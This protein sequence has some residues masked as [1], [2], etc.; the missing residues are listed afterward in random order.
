MSLGDREWRLIRERRRPGPLTMALEEVAARTVSEGGPATVRVYTW[1]DVL[2]LGYS[3][4]TDTVDWEYCDREGVAVTRRPTGGGGI[5]HDHHGDLSYGIVAPADALPGDLMESY[6]LLCRPVVSALER[7]G[8][9]ASF[10]DRELPAV[11]EPACYLRAIHPAHDLLVDGRKVSGNAQYRQRSAVVQHGSVSV[12]SAAERHLGVFGDP[13]SPARFRQRVTA[14]DEHAAV[15]RET[16]VET[17]ETTLA[18]FVDAT[19]GEWTDEELAAAR[20]L[21]ARKY[22]DDRWVRRRRDPTA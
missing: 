11:H 17:L 5:Y 3:Q 22:D 16:V 19:P 13:V 4:E 20:D 6:G 7:L 21:A 2:S 9:P 10:A 15:D 18:E 12:A 8:V 14:V 1:P